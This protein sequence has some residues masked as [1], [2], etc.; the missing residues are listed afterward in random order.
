MTTPNICDICGGNLKSLAHAM[1]CEGGDN[2]TPP[3]DK[4]SREEC[5]AFNIWWKEVGKF[6]DPDTEDVPWFDKRKALAEAAFSAGNKTP[7]AKPAMRSEFLDQRYQAGRG[8]IYD[9]KSDDD[10]LAALN[11]WGSETYENGLEFAHYILL[12]YSKRIYD[13][14]GGMSHE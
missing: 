12:N 4:P 11:Y 10:L 9:K 1:Q 8:I 14:L 6:F 2:P 7:P 5:E 13:A 3:T